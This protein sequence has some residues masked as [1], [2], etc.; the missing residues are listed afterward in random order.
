MKVN[1]EGTANIINAALAT[2]VK[3]LM[4][5]SSVAAIGRS[6]GNEVI[7]EDTPWED[8]ALNSNYAI[9]KFLS[10]REVWRGVAEGLNAVI[11]NPSLPYR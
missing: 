10:E 7:H 6:R 1:V 8:S 3:K 2:G 11:V 4:H 5:V 9:T